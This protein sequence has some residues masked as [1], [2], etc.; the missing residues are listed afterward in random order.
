MGK[1]HGLRIPS[2]APKR[3]LKHCFFFKFTDLCD[4][5]LPSGF[6]WISNLSALVRCV[7]L[8]DFDEKIFTWRFFRPSLDF[9]PLGIGAQSL[10]GY[11]EDFSLRFL[12]FVSPQICPP[13][14]ISHG[15][16]GKLNFKRLRYASAYSFGFFILCLFSALLQI[17][18]YSYVHV[19]KW[20]LNKLRS[21]G[22]GST[23]VACL[24][25]FPKFVPPRLGCLPT[26][27]PNS[28]QYQL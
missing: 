13:P 4:W 6:P 28:T 7:I 21:S 14:I 1:S 19:S 24:N 27:G 16:A 9:K 3:W 26:Y 15:V 18:A 22:W 10:V 25:F 5:T 17:F 11:D 8:V 23:L 20:F 12:R 2:S